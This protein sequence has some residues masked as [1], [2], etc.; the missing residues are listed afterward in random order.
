MS[1]A[2]LKNVCPQ[3]KFYGFILYC[4]VVL[5]SLLSIFIGC[6][7][8]APDG[9]SPRSYEQMLVFDHRLSP[10]LFCHIRNFLFQK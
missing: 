5:L 10:F 6:T 8:S 2:K 7:T 1:F 3:P 4:L 9:S